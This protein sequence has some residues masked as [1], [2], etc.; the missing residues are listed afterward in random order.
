MG[1]IPVN[2][3]ELEDSNICAVSVLPIWAMIDNLKPLK[4]QCLRANDVECLMEVS[5]LVCK[6]PLCG[7]ASPAE[8]LMVNR[9][10][11]LSWTELSHLV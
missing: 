3:S 10:Y 11:V 8:I 9:F 7:W 5:A 1:N 2:K 6:I 4:Q